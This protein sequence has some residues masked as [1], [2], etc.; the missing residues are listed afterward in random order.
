[1]HWRYE[2]L[3]LAP[4]LRAGRNVLAAIV[5]NWGSERPVAQFSYHT[6][7]LLQGDGARES[8]ANTNDEWKVLHNEGYESVP[9]RAGDVGGYYAAPPGE[10]VNGSLYPWG[11]EQAD[12]DD[13]RWSNAATV[14]GWNAEITRLRGSHQ[15]GEAWGWHL[16]PR[17]IPP[18]EERI[19][20]YAHV[21][22][23]SGVAPDDGFLLGRTDLTIP[24]NSR[25]SLLLDQSHLTNAYA[26]LSVSGGAGSKVTLTYAE[27]L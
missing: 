23:A 8:I 24:P 22:R 25:A 2:T 21:R 13:E 1:M 12:Y 18:M 5:W 7:F 27:A 14:T 17:S 4:Y 11:W 6:G 16:V 20:R 15:T 9:V 26:V 19:V 10:S 3:D